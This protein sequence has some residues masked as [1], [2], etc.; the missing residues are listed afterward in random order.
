MAPPTSGA[1]YQVSQLRWVTHQHFNLKYCAFFVNFDP[2]KLNYYLK[3]FN[4]Y[5]IKFKFGKRAF[6]F[7]SAD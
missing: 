1:G 3:I 6:F 4:I 5:L 2:I 7:R